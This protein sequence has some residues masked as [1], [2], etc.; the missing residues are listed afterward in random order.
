MLYYNISFQAK[1]ADCDLLPEAMMA[2]HL[3]DV[4]NGAGTAKQAQTVIHDGAQPL[5]GRTGKMLSAWAMLIS[6]R[7]K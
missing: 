4:I 3:T 7:S 1:S 5:S 2:N 6:A